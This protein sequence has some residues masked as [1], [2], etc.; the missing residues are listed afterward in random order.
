MDGRADDDGLGLRRSWVTMGMS[1]PVRRSVK[2]HHSRSGVC[3]LAW[4][5][6]QPAV[7]LTTRYPGGW[8]PVAGRGRGCAKP[9]RWT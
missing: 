5:A 1:A 7:G 9:S 8:Q 4:G 3:L 6:W 2:P